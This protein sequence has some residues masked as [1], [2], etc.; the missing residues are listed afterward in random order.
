MKLKQQERVGR[1]RGVNGKGRN[2]GMRLSTM[3]L[4]EQI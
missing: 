3:R 4:K 1:R 2:E